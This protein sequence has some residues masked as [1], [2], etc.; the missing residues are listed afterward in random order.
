[1][2]LPEALREALRVKEL[3]DTVAYLTTAA[4]DGVPNVSLQ[5]F[6]DVEGDYVLLPDLFAQKTKVN[7]NENLRGALTIA[8]PSALAGWVLEGPAGVI[9]WGHPPS[10]RFH[11][12]RAGAVLERWGDWEQREPI[13]SL[14]EAL[15]PAVIAQR[16][17]IV[18]KVERVLRPGGEP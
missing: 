3:D 16:G 10:Y 18:L 6:T 13:Q 2:S 9:Q 14:P 15:R 12:L 4:L 17:V 1:M 7:L 5:P 8:S 11:D